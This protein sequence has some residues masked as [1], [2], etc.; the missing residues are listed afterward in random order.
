MLT[1]LRSAR[2]TKLRARAE[3]RTA[4]YTYVLQYCA[5]L[6]TKFRVVSIAMSA[7][8]AVH[9]EIQLL[10]CVVATDG[11][12]DG[13]ESRTRGHEK[14]FAVFAT[15]ATV[16]GHLGYLDHFDFV[17]FWIIDMYTADPSEVEISFFVQRD[18]VRSQIGEHLF[19]CQGR[20]VVDLKRVDFSRR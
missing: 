17:S 19:L 4:G 13:I 5:A 2:I 12:V 14:C 11:H 15:E 20:V 8:G 10:C 16:G 1:Y 7:G 6:V 3:T 18:A 9:N